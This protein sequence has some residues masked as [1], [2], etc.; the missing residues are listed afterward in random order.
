MKNTI[1][2]ALTVFLTGCAASTPQEARDMGPERHYRFTVDQDY[3]AVYR[4]LLEAERTCFQGGALITASM[5]ANGELYPDTRSAEI[6]VGL[7]GIVA[8]INQVVSIKGSDGRTEVDAIITA[9]NVNRLGDK[10]KAWASG[11]ATA[12]AT[13]C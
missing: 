10:I 12:G 11:S 2:A 13:G 4:R 3:Q 6:T 9:G 5:I 7:Y 1:I 8:M